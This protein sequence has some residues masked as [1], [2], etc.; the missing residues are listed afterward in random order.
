MLSF[1]SWCTCKITVLFLPMKLFIDRSVGAYFFAHPV[2]LNIHQSHHSDTDTQPYTDR[3][4]D[5][6]TDSDL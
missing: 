1:L 3:Q 2:Y 6:Q 4:T 5:R